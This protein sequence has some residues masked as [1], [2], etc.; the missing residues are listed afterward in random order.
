MSFLDT[1]HKKKSFTLTTLLLSVLLLLLF[2]VGL[3]YM[4][5]PEE[6][7]I[8]VNFG[9]MDFGKGNVQPKEKIKS[10]PV[11]TTKEV[12]EEQQE[13]VKPVAEPEVQQE[14]AL[15]KAAEKLVTQDNEESILIKQKQEAKRKA[16]A[17]AKKAKA[18][19][20]RKEQQRVAAEKAE[21]ERKR[22]AEQAKRDKVDN[23]F[24][25]LAKSDGK[26]TGGEG[27]DNK[28]GDKGNPQGN[29]YATSYYG[30]P[31]SGSGGSGYGLS[32]RKLLNKG[33]VK[34]DCNEEGRV[35]VKI[36]VDRNGKVLSATAGV[37]GTTNNH[38]CLL[39][40][41]EA[42]ARLHKWNLD[43]K[44]PSRQIGFV[45]VNFKLGE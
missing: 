34:Q 38:P 21:A 20:E 5:P 30:S 6:K 22:K 15:E 29:P 3:T 24:G 26:A 43:T 19:A 16:D 31:G 27:D 25:G 13:E 23:L 14:S 40:P 36:V 39:K 45:V 28:A 11:K 42:T 9:Q 33:Q 44:A 17:A 2:Y 4:D 1:K 41:A 7:G 35:V 37:K 12:V 32:G 10:E 8:A 18:E